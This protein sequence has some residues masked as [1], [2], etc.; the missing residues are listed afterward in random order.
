MKETHSRLLDR[1]GVGRSQVA[2]GFGLVQVASDDDRV[3]LDPEAEGSHREDGGRTFSPS[4]V[5]G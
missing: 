4:G 5:C 1:R 2:F 3:L